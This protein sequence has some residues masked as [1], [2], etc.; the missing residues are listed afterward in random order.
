MF[1]PSEISEAKM[2]QMRKEVK[3][4]II[5]ARIGLLLRHPWFG[6]MATRLVVKEADSWCPTAATNGRDLYFNTQFFNSLD[7][8]EIEFVIA[9]E[10]LHCAFDHIVRRE[11]RIPDLYNIACDYLVNNVL[12]REKIGEQPKNIQIFKSTEFNDWIS[13]EIYDYL[14]KNAQKIN[15][16]DMGELLDVHVDWTDDG[17]DYKKGGKNGNGNGPPTLS[18]EE[19]DSIRDDVKENMISASQS[20][21]IGNTPGEIKRLIGDLTNPKMDWRQILQ[22]QIQS[23]IRNDYS[24][25]RPS[26]KGWHTNAILP[27]LERDKEVKVSIALDMSG[28]ISD[29]QARDFLS[30]VQGIMDQ[31]ANYTIDVWCFDTQV[32]NHETFTSDDGE[33]I[34]K[35]DIQ[36]GGGTIFDCNWEYMKDNNI[37]PEQ[38]LM[39]TDMY[40]SSFGD[41]DYCDTVFINH[42]RP[43]FEAPFGITVPYE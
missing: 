24:F 31:Y 26:R 4:K 13:E 32:Y 6:N 20:V 34:T 17:Q 16:D 8:K 35:Y 9:H 41:P 23:S 22:Q 10:I 43:G 14:F 38:F 18:K 30:E 19:L 33:D 39:F 3:E 2:A 29:D 25:S 37:V 7:L 40:S 12:I 5:T 15:L 27:G 11:N 36:G 21:G 42:G 28:S 1:E